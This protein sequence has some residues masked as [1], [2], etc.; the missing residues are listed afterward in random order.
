MFFY[1]KK[2]YIYPAMATSLF[3]SYKNYVN[4]PKSPN[5]NNYTTENSKILSAI[6]L[7]NWIFGKSALYG[8][9]FPIS[10][11]K[12]IKDGENKECIYLGP[13]NI[14]SKLETN[15]VPMSKYNIEKLKIAPHAKEK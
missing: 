10:L 3:I 9:F 13:N 2:Y 4:I 5:I 1:L 8:L 15:Y 6:A 7:G 14:I 11:C 12:I